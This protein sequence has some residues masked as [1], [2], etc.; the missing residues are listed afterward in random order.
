MKNRL[1]RVWVVRSH[2]LNGVASQGVHVV[3][4]LTVTCKRRIIVLGFFYIVILSYRNQFGIIHCTVFFVLFARESQGY[5]EGIER[6]KS[7]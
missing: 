5:G 3:G 6:H 1:S 2:Q 7:T 4:Q